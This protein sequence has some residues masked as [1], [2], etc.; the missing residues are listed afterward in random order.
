M[1]IRTTFGTENVGVLLYTLPG[2]SAPV[3]VEQILKNRSLF[4]EMG[5]RKPEHTELN[6]LTF[7]KQNLSFSLMISAKLKLTAIR[8]LMIQSSKLSHIEISD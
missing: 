5:F 7:V 8:G 1:V 2:Y 6:H 3:E 4:G